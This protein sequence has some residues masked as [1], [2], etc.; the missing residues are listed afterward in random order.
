MHST[1]QHLLKPSIAFVPASPK[2]RRTMALPLNIPAAPYYPASVRDRV[3]DP[4]TP[5]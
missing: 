1:V 5:L 3:V 2:T 4:N